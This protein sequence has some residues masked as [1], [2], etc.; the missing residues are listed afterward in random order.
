MLTVAVWLMRSFLFLS[1]NHSTLLSYD[2][3]HKYLV[4][5]PTPNSLLVAA[6]TLKHKSNGFEGGNLI[7][8]LLML[9][10]FKKKK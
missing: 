7:P 8:V 3:S 9:I 5:C 4:L 6:V 1:D 10:L 2:K